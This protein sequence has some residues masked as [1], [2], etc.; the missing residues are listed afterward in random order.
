MSDREKAIKILEGMPD[1]VKME[2]IIEELYLRIKTKKALKDVES[3]NVISQEEIE[4]E[5]EK[6]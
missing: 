5:I 2:D 4:Q 6:W 3:E 1:N